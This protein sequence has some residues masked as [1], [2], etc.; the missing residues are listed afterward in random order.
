M[1]EDLAQK[2]IADDLQ[3]CGLRR[4]GLVL[5]HSSLKSMG[6]VPGG[7]E[8]V[9]RGLID[10]IGPRGTLL[11]PA[12][13]YATVNAEQPVFDVANT[14]SCVGAITEYFRTRNGTIRSVHPTHSICGLG[15]NAKDMLDDHR[16]DHTP[17]GANSPYRKLSDRGGQVLMLGCGLK[18]NTSM[19][20]VEE[21]VEPPYL[22]GQ[23]ITYRII[24]P[25]GSESE[26]ACRR[27]GFAGFRQRYDRIGPLLE[28]NGMRIGKVLEATAHILDCSRL[29]EAGASALR[30][31][32]LF[33][34]ERR[35]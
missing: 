8:T 35:V 22:F 15:P 11:M 31:D 30:R 6:H 33:F 3:A 18:P 29:W 13:S 5:V 20:G 4:G 28:G 17:C 32:P 10:A 16:R 7:C 24:L 14:P 27:H 1:T 25:D 19:H 34:V 23:T 26:M 2:R 21:L 12:L 9:V